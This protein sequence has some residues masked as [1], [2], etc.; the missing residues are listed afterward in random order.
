MRP[1]TSR[2]IS[3]T[4]ILR[5]YHQQSTLYDVLPPSM[6]TSKT[7]SL[8]FTYYQHSPIRQSKTNF[9]QISAWLNHTEEVT[10][11][12][13]KKHSIPYSRQHRKATMSSLSSV[14]TD[15]PGKREK[16]SEVLC[17]FFFANLFESERNEYFMMTHDRVIW[18]AIQF[19]DV[20]QAKIDSY[21]QVL[22]VLGTRRHK[23]TH[24]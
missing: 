14:D 12:T 13:Q 3:S 5:Q 19:A 17:A 16:A 20:F 23:H 8:P 18:L 2:R 15:Q 6:S 22:M 1:I 9:E 11:V 24:T 4:N 10:E 7:V 21:H